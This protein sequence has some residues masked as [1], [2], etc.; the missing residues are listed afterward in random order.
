MTTT[1][2]EIAAVHRAQLR[3]MPMDAI[4]AYLREQGHGDVAYVLETRSRGNEIEIAINRCGR[5]P[6]FRLDA[7]PPGYPPLADEDA[8]P[9]DGEDRRL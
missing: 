5:A 1:D 2:T 3:D 7:L 8:L 9:F 6:S 4:M